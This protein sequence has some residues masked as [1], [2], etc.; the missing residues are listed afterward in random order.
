[1]NTKPTI[2]FK[3]NPNILLGIVDIAR[4]ECNKAM[5]AAITSKQEFLQHGFQRFLDALDVLEAAA[6]ESKRQERQQQRPQESHAWTTP[7]DA[8]IEPRIF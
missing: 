6:I 7:K 3:M 5:K 1:M 8:N 4:G 2:S